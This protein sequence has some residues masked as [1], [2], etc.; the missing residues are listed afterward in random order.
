ML[1]ALWIAADRW[2]AG[3]GVTCDSYRVI[4][5][6]P[7]ASLREYHLF[8]IE[9]MASVVADIESWWHQAID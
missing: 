8:D 7:S 3:I 4:M 1:A 6:V 5:L 9:T 2:N